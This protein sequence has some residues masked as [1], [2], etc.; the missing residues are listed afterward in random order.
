MAT[1]ASLRDLLP[2]LILGEHRD[3]IPL[4]LLLGQEEATDSD[5]SAHSSSDAST[6]PTTFSAYAAGLVGEL[7]RLSVSNAVD[8]GHIIVG[9]LVAVGSDYLVVRDASAN[10]IGLG[11][12]EHLSIPLA[13]VVSIERLPLFLELLPF[14]TRYP[15]ASW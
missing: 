6:V 9:R 10:G 1:S 13:N 3:L 11:F 12:H 15:S 5:L 4:L 14:L 7:V 2:L 8:N